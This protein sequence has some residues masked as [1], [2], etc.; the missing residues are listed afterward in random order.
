MKSDIDRW[1]EKYQSLPFSTVIEPDP[2]LV[3]HQNLLTGNGRSLDI[4]CGTCD[5]ALYLAQ[6]GYASYAVD[7]SRFGVEHCLRKAHANALSVF[8]FVADLEGYPFPE[9]VFDV[10]VVFRYLDRGLI[11]TL[12]QTLKSG[13]L[14][15]FKTFNERFLLKKPSFPSAYVLAHGELARWFGDWACVDTD[16]SRDAGTASHWV[17]RKP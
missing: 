7:G 2:L 8:P 11:P 16:D 1:N 5:N 3:K 10:M 17:G 12:R 15:F 9:A 6:R 14:L 13:G 4:A